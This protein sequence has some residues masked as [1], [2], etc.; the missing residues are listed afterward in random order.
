MVHVVIIPLK[1]ACRIKCIFSQ[2]LSNHETWLLPLFILTLE[3]FPV[4][5]L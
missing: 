2:K 4:A 3:Y 1:K 5:C